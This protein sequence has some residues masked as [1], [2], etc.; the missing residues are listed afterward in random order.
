MKRTKSM[1]YEETVESR[2]LVLYTENNYECYRMYEQISKNLRRKM[3]SGV[4]NAEKAIDA[5]YPLTTYAS[6]LYN[7]EFGFRF[8]VQQRFTAAADIAS[9]WEICFEE[10]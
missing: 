10:L 5:F 8:S 9:M 1:Y 3:Y 6:D 2:E 4:Y 7:R